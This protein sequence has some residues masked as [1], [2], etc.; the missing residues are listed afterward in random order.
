MAI[1]EREERSGRLDA[2]AATSLRRWM[3]EEGYS[4]QCAAIEE[5][6]R[7]GAFEELQDAFGAVIPF[8][9][10]GRRG[11]MGPGPNRINERTIGESA[12]GLCRHVLASLKEDA[13]GASRPAPG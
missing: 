11:A 7:R 5:L 6:I 12:E 4:S 3:S 8:G 1:V 13:K 10:G 9:T 2:A